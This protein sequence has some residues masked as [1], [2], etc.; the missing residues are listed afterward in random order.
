MQMMQIND[1]G[2]FVV[3]LDGSETNTYYYYV[4]DAYVDVS[5]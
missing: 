5:T 3:Q 2:A 4:D 1:Q